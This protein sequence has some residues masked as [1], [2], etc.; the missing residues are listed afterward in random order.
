[1]LIVIIHKPDK[2]TGIYLT[3]ILLKAVAWLVQFC[4]VTSSY[5][6]VTT[7]EE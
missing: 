6:N 3:T 1:M 5:D 7:Q 2:Q 4:R